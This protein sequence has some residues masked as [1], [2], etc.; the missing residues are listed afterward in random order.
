MNDISPNAP[1][2]RTG[3]SS[4]GRVADPGTGRHQAPAPNRRADQVQLSQVAQMFSRLRE[5]PVIRD[6][7]VAHVRSEVQAGTYDIERK[8]GIAVD[9]M[10]K[11]VDEW[12]TDVF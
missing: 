8:M 12:P 4:I 10:I 1:I 5:I 2:G 9:E 3:F 6:D 11:D 7:L